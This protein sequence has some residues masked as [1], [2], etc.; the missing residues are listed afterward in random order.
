MANVKTADSLIPSVVNT[1]LDARCRVA[2]EEDIWNI[3]LP[4]VGMLVYVIRTGKFYKI[5]ALQEKNIGSLNVADAAV[6]EYREISE[7]PDASDIKIKDAR[8]YFQS[9][10][11]EDALQEAGER[12]K[13][14]LDA[15]KKGKA[16]G[17]ASLDSSGKIPAAQLPNTASTSTITL[18]VPHDPDGQNISL[19]LDLSLT[20]SFNEQDVDYHRISMVNNYGAMKIFDH[21][22]WR[23][24]TQ[25]S[26]GVPQY[27]GAISFTLDDNLLP[28]YIPGN[29]YYG[30][31]CWM[32]SSGASDEWIGFTFCGDVNDMRPIRLPDITET[33][34]YDIGKKSGSLLVDYRHGE[35]QKVTLSGATEITQDTF[36]NIPAGQAVLLNVIR[37]GNSLLVKGRSLESAAV[38]V[39]AVNAGSLNIVAIETE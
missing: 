13:N 25:T 22:C 36:L 24:L 34:I 17:V 37:N 11:I 39:V 14:K 3:E 6:A 35:I 12:L 2:V 4:F 21:D 9:E 16:G 30:R 15:D 27:G 10:N 20:G 38:M 18:V 31:Y 28:G 26:V 1:P 32:D 19:I 23:E 29:K 7:T 33:D 5:T 8:G